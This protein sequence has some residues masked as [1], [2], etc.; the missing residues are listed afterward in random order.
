MFCLNVSP[1]PRWTLWDLNVCEQHG[2]TLHNYVVVL[3]PS[4]LLHWRPL[5]DLEALQESPRSAPG[6]LGSG[7]S[8]PVGQSSDSV[9][10]TSPRCPLH[11]SYAACS[12]ETIR[13]VCDWLIGSLIDEWAHWLGVSFVTGLCP[14]VNDG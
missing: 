12:E 8:A 9:I 1:V 2:V 7:H 10:I 11:L 4:G 5:Y 13:H 6:S 3:P 14:I